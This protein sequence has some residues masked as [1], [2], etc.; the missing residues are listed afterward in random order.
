[1]TQKTAKNILDNIEI[2]TAFANGKQIQYKFVNY[3]GEFIR[4]ED[5]NNC[6]HPEYLE[7]GRYRIKPPEQRDTLVPI[8]YCCHCP[9]ACQVCSARFNPSKPKKKRK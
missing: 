6:I 2:F 4:W 5:I 7:P 1:M 3:Q 8:Y 9:M